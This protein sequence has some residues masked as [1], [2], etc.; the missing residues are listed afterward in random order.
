M[1]DSASSQ[2]NN[3]DESSTSS[4]QKFG[5]IVDDI[6]AIS[7]RFLCI[8]CILIIEDPI[9]LECGHR[10]CRKCFEIRA[11]A[12]ADGNVKCPYEDCNTIT[13]STQV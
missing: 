13:N 6:L 9:Q 10:S 12:T 11:A 1:A 8:F 5:H 4:Y 7:S 3:E 2:R